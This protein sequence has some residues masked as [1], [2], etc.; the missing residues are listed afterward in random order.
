M[1]EESLIA[2]SEYASY[3][4]MMLAI[5]FA[6]VDNLFLGYFIWQH[7]GALAF[8]A[9]SLLNTPIA[10]LY[11]YYTYSKFYKDCQSVKPSTLWEQLVEKLCDPSSWVY[12]VLFIAAVMG[13]YFL[14]NIY[15]GAMFIQILKLFVTQMGLTSSAGYYLT[16]T[17]VMCSVIPDG[18]LYVKDL[19]HKFCALWSWEAFSDLLEDK[20][21]HLI[22]LVILVTICSFIFAHLEFSQAINSYQH[23]MIEV[24]QVF[25]PYVANKA[26]IFVCIFMSVFAQLYGMAV[27]FL[28]WLQSFETHSPLE[29]EVQSYGKLFCL[30]II[31]AS[32]AVG[33]F[34]MTGE[35]ASNPFNIDSQRVA[36]FK[37][38]TG[39]Y[40]CYCDGLDKQAAHPH[41]EVM[42]QV[43][44]ALLTLSFLIM[45]FTHVVQLSLP[46]LLL[47]AGVGFLVSYFYPPQ[48][49]LLLDK[50][51][52]VSASFSVAGAAFRDENSP[53]L[54][55]IPTKTYA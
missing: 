48:M 10:T 50:Q 54:P 55:K 45:G 5:V 40:S 51:V 18:I 19:F 35:L 30:L 15:Y 24:L 28:S 46:I 14:F 37:S 49:L 1:S 25:I 52:V 16:M 17:L 29:Y 33:Q 47:S 2:S 44:L 8:V 34:L 12:F 13:T 36:I 31:G 9:I 43:G 11:R 41:V 3:I 32:R 53:S 26:C 23:F 4:L 27:G 7:L 6:V 22:A 21:G 20:K 39:D 42:M 38:V